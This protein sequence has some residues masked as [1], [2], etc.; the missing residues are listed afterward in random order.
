M[1][2]IAN[3]WLNIACDYQSNARIAMEYLNI[4]K[5][6]PPRLNTI[7][8]LNHD[9]TGMMVM[10]P[11]WRFLKSRRGLATWRASRP[12][13]SS[14]VSTRHPPRRRRH[15]A[16]HEQFPVGSG[17]ELARYGQQRL[18]ADGRDLV[19]LQSIPGLALY[20]GGLTRKKFAINTA[21]MTFY[22]FGAVLVIWVLAGFNFGFGQASVTIRTRG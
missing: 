22:A 1:A 14:S 4:L 2:A 20:Y 7:R 21:L 19:G 6:G 5:V 15:P 8:W 10:A 3:E 13:S 18:D 9:K 17:P 16:E 12:C 11:S